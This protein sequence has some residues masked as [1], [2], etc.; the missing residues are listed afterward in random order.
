MNKRH[1]SLSAQILTLGI[2]LVVLVSLAISII[3]MV[4]INSLTEKNIK[5]Q[6]EI[7]LQYLNADLRVVMTSF[8]DM[9]ENG[10]AIFNSIPDNA[11]AQ[12]IFVDLGATIPDVLSLYYGSVVSRHSPGG[13]Y[14]DSSGWEPEYE[15]DPP[16][17]V[18]HQSAMANPGVTML[19]DPYV[20]AETNELVITIA[21]TVR[22]KNGSITGVIAI[23]VLLDKLTA[24]V[25]SEKITDDGSTVLIDKD[26]AYIVHPDISY[27]LEKN[28]FDERPELNKESTLGGK[29]NVVFHGNNYVAS[30]PVD[31]TDW[32]FVSTGSLRTLKAEARRILIFVILAVIGI[33]G[34]SALVALVL[35]RSLTKPFK[36]LAANF[37]V[38]SKGDLTVS[39]PDYISMEAS[40][41]SNGFN[42]F[43]GGISS[44]VRNIKDSAD[45]IKNAADD[46]S[47]SIAE[48]DRTIGMVKE[49]VDGILKDIGRENESITQS[50]TAITNVMKSIEKLNAKIREQS[51][52]I[53][54]SSSAIEE[55]AASI[56]SI[57]NSIVT[58][59][60]NIN[61][62]VQS[63]IEEKKRLAAS[64]EI[65]K[66]VE[67]ESGALMDMNVVIAT[68]ASQTN[69][70]SMN[71]AIEAAHAGE[72]GK[73]FAVVAEEIRKLAEKTASQSKGSRETLLSIQ[74]KIQ[75]IA[76]SSAH[77]EQSFSGMI[78]I[79]NDINQLSAALKVSTTEQG[80]GSKQL[81][82]SIAAINTITSEIEKDSSAMQANSAEA[83][84]ACR[85]LTELSL[86]VSTAVEKCENGVT[87][88]TED[89]KTVVAA[90]EKTRASVDS[91]EKEVN[92]FKV[93]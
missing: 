46:L 14:I 11:A 89:S 64:A 17:R 37:D 21:R 54:A 36:K 38:I 7:S 63:S 70:L 66:T 76:A 47:R 33:G 67:Q 90:A 92:H 19:V 93:K 57:Q 59:D 13:I 12:N 68:V 58:M 18:W 43:T 53:S 49:E 56:N 29:I 34:F 2:A 79:I 48:T 27:V 1:I 35:S 5:K 24:I 20:D 74:K 91:L 51:S 10:A 71:A 80:A 81:L 44:M 55:M 65:T 83:V 30:S 22:D 75:E 3:F 39:S 86:S 88:L 69:L 31:G 45:N 28:L 16:N 61:E 62:L 73:G 15:W 25:L 84:S 32:Y 42:F 60:A 8:T 6:A 26:G 40:A 41:L 87:S 78:Q 72:S 52:Q 77:V 50:E 85:Q 4:N 82:S 23:D 9:V